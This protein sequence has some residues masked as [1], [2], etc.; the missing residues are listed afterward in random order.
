M[1]VN[2]RP[3]VGCAQRSRQREAERGEEAF[4]FFRRSNGLFLPHFTDDHCVC[5]YCTCSRPPETTVHIIVAVIVLLD[6]SFVV[7]ISSLLSLPELR[8]SDVDVMWR[9]V[10]FSAM[11]TGPFV[12]GE[13]TRAPVRLPCEHPLDGRA[14][15]R[16]T[17]R[18]AVT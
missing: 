10:A 5:C 12:S 8:A 4:G 1:L 9:R 17:R 13:R 14:L 15:G 6:N 2:T 7:H 16:L 11:A 18:A 3:P